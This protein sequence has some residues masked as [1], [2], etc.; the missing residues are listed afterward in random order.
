MGHQSPGLDRADADPRRIEIGRDV[1][2]VLV[3]HGLDAAVARDVHDDLARVDREALELLDHA[4]RPGVGGLDELGVAEV[5]KARGP[6]EQ[7]GAALTDLPREL[8]RGER[9]GHQR[10]D[11]RVEPAPEST[12]DGIPRDAA[13]PVER[14]LRVYRRRRFEPFAFFGFRTALA[15][16]EVCAFLAAFFAGFFADCSEPPS[17]SWSAALFL[18]GRML[19]P[20]R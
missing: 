15:F 14:D 20:K 18:P 10:G 7:P 11:A 5:G 13:A 1:V 19:S 17:M 2:V 12:R 9:P 3:V 16:F 8:A 4:G 6:V